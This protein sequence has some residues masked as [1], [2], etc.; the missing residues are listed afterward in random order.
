VPSRSSAGSSARRGSAFTVELPRTL[1]VERSGRDAWFTEIEGR[2]L[3]LSNLDKV[4]W[5]DEG[6]TKGDLL[7]YYFNVADLLL[8]YLRDRPLTRKRMPDGIDGPFFYEKNAPM[9]TPDWMPRCPVPSEDAKA[10]LIDY[11]M[12]DSLAGMLFVVNLGAIEFHPLHSRCGTVEQPDYLFFDLDPF[13]PITFDDVLTVAGHVRVALD[14][15]GLVGYPKTSGATG[16]QIYVP[17]EPGYGYDQIRELVGR[18]GRMINK[19]DPE[20]TT[21]LWEVR[22]RSGKVFIDHNMNRLGANI[23]AVYSMRPEPMATVS[24]PVTWDEV[25]SGITPQDFTIATVWERFARVGDLFERVRTAPQDLTNALEALGLPTEREFPVPARRPSGQQAAGNGRRDPAPRAAGAEGKREDPEA[26]ERTSEEVIAASKDPTLAEYL[27][28]RTFGPEGTPEPPPSAPKRP[29]GNTFVIQKH[30]ATRLHYD[31]RLERHGAMPSWAVPKGLPIARNDRRL[32]VHTE[33]HPIEYASFQGTIPEGHYGA[34]EVRIFDDGT[35]DLVEWEDKKVSFVLHGRRYPGLEYHLVQTRTDWLIFLASH[36]ETPLIASPGSYVPM[37]AEAGGKPFDGK[38]WWFE[39][40]LDGIRALATMSTGETRLHTRNGRDVSDA[41]PELHMIHELVNQVNAVV[42]GEIVAFEADGRPSFELLQQRMNLKNEREIKRMSKQIPVTLVAFDLLW[43]DGE[44]LTGLPL[45]QRRELLEG[46]V[47]RDDRLEV[48]T[49]V[50]GEGKAFVDAARKLRLEGVVAKKKGSRYEPGRR[51]P[52]WK[53][54]K[55][56]NTQD[57]VILGW[58]R[59]EGS[60]GQ[61]FGALLVGAFVDGEL[62]WIGQVGTGFTQKMQ[63]TV[64]EQLTPLV[65]KTPAI[66]DKEL[67]AVKGATFV[68]PK[69]VCEVE[70]LEMT[71]STNKMR[72]PSFKG[73]RPDKGPDETVLERPVV[74]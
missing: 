60:R 38:E 15:L 42:D 30:R 17:I 70:Y 21:M 50:E 47:E 61:T 27:R 12:V 44:E 22:R 73:L 31:L 13:P 54:I 57:C 58:T 45:E 8:P 41:Y 43:L 39:P 40:K 19:A 11:L 20:R 18:I 32:A 72:A 56:T 16:M 23:A 6:Y 66:D 74:A 55:L 62:K 4:F 52:N 59:G 49:H 65:R 2:E 14:A 3:R 5:P 51:T 7:N 34:G 25:E 1:E 53:K 69:I 35:Y 46:V 10:G 33:D 28:K 37:L 71:K 64:L 63:E 9:K 36:Q 67:K 29:K 48:V 24:T 68:E 26:A